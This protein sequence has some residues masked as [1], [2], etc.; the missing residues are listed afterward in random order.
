MPLTLAQMH[1]LI[2]DGGDNTAEDVRDV[3]EALY[4]WIPASDRYLAGRQADE[5]AHADDEFFS[6]G[7]PATPTTPTIQTVSGTATWLEGRNLLS[8]RF[9]DQTN[10]DASAVLYPIAS[11]SAPMTIETRL[12]LTSPYADFPEAGVLFTD[13]TLA[14]SS[15]YGTSMF[16]SDNAFTTG[17]VVSRDGTLTALVSNGQFYG[18]LTNGLA[19]GTPVIIYLRAVWKAANTWQSSVSIDGVSYGN[20]GLADQTFTMTPTHFGVFV[21]SGG[22]TVEWQASFDY[23]RVYDAD[24]SA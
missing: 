8:C 16:G 2:A 13:G 21:S 19:N 3:I 1:A 12:R 4:D 20:R 15:L 9:E 6:G 18:G 23:L 5:T 14:T 10:G 22:N 24:L 7:A 11:A 17:G